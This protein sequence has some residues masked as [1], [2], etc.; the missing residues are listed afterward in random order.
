MSIPSQFPG[1]DYREEVIVWYNGRL[2]SVHGC[3]CFRQRTKATDVAVYVT[4]VKWK[5]T[6]HIAGMKDSRWTIGS[7]ECHIT[8]GIRSAGRP[9]HRWRDDSVGQWGERWTGTAKNQQSWRTVVFKS[10]KCFTSHGH[11][12]CLT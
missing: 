8:K 6:W 11:I 4:K 12:S 1:L 9:K 2:D 3:L 10:S 5:W 7:T